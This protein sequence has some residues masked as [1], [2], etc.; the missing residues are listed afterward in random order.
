MTLSAVAIGVA[1][2]LSG[3]G[4]KDAA[5]QQAVEVPA[6]NPA[7]QQA[8]VA[9][10]MQPT[11]ATAP[12]APPEGAAQ[13]PAQNTAPPQ[14]VKMYTMAEVATHNTPQDCWTVIDGGVADVTSFFGTHPGGDDKLAQACGKDAT[15]LFMA[16]AKHDPKGFAKLKTFIIGSLKVQ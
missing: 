13:K 7:P 8:V 15:Q 1:V 12:V 16:Q 2:V 4:A 5:Q 10:D 11:P 14:G 9:P 3:C 6:Q